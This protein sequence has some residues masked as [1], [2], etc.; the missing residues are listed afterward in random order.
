MPDSFPVQSILTQQQRLDAGLDVG[1]GFGGQPFLIPMP[2]PTEA[3]PL[4]SL[5]RHDP[6]QGLHHLAAR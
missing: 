2:L 6:R 3:E 5:V 1:G 4:G